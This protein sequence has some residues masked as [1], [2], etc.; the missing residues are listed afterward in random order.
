LAVT[1]SIQERFIFDLGVE[2][3]D[4][5]RRVV[6]GERFGNAPVAVTDDVTG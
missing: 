4:A 2:T 1:S 5:F 3:G 6:G